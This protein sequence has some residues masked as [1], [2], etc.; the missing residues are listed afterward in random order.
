[1]KK[2][3]IWKRRI[4]RKEKWRK[5]IRKENVEGKSKEKVPGAACWHW[6]W[7]SG[8]SAH[9]TRISRCT[10]A[11]AR[12]SPLTSPTHGIAPRPSRFRQTVALVARVL[13]QVPRPPTPK[14]LTQVRSGQPDFC[15][16]S[17]V[18]CLAARDNS[19]HRPLLLFT[20]CSSRASH[21]QVARKGHERD[22]C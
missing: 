7:T 1:M 2:Q 8:M 18:V 4:E 13:S 9:P 19:W 10:V 20:S 21:A 14:P 11:E 15:S 17:V 16:C 12:H 6:P 3:T 5:K 22:R